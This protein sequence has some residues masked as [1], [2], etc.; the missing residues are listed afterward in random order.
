MRQN[1]RHRVIDR[2]AETAALRR[3]VDER[4]RLLLNARVLI[5]D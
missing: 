4:N 3:D 5:H 2:A 1:A